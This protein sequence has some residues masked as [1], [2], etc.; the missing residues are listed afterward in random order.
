MSAKGGLRTFGPEPLL[1][2]GHPRQALAGMA[3]GRGPERAWVIKAANMQKQHVGSCNFLKCEGGTAARTEAPHHA[4][5]ALKLSRSTF[6]ELDM[7]AAVVGV[8]AG[9]R[10]GVL[11]AAAAVAPTDAD[12]LAFRPEPDRPAE[13]P[14]GVRS[15]QVH[16]ILNPNVARVHAGR[17]WWETA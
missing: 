6:G 5:R 3:R 12:R 15:V 8:T 9:R 13:A 7:V 11:A 10:A 14:P 2:G 4:G 17:R 1:D 16:N